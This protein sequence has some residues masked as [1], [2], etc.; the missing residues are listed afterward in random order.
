[1]FKEEKVVS[2]VLAL[3]LIAGMFGCAGQTSE[4][5]E[6]GVS[7]D[8]ISSVE[9]VSNTTVSENDWFEDS[10][11]TTQY[12]RKYLSE[13]EITD[14]DIFSASEE[15]AIMLFWNVLGQCTPYDVDWNYI[16]GSCTLYPVFSNCEDLFD[17]MGYFFQFLIPIEFS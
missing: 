9:S 16:K 13:N 6:S 1:M 15:W 8:R 10:N 7:S 17:V 12:T 2:L 3:A 11:F 4:K 5:T 14:S